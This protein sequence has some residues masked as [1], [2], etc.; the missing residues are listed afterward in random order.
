MGWNHQ[1]DN[2]FCWSRL[3]SLPF[4]CRSK[5]PSMAASDSYRQGQGWRLE[6][7]P[8]KFGTFVDAAVRHCSAMRMSTSVWSWR[9]LMLRNNIE[10]SRTIMQPLRGKTILSLRLAYH[11]AY[12]F[13]Y[14]KAGKERWAREY[15]ECLPLRA[16]RAIALYLSNGKGEASGMESF[17]LYSTCRS[18]PVWDNVMIP[19]YWVSRLVSYNFHARWRWGGWDVSN[20]VGVFHRTHCRQVERAV[21]CAIHRGRTPGVREAKGQGFVARCFQVRAGYNRYNCVSLVP[22]KQNVT[23]YV[24]QLEKPLKPTVAWKNMKKTYTMCFLR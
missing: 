15:A 13:Y 20:E 17:S 5:N 3:T 7:L 11:A 14:M 21:W 16:R 10:M 1:L 18:P 8:R 9:L 24:H 22:G 6:V 23:A 12:A 2:E 19:A 4:R